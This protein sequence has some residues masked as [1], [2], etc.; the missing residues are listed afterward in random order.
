MIDG[1]RVSFSSIPL[2]VPGPAPWAWDILDFNDVTTNPAASVPAGHY[3][4]L[5][6]GN[7]FEVVKD[8]YSPGTGFEY[9]VVSPK[10][11]L[12]T[13]SYFSGVKVKYEIYFDKPFIMC[14]NP[15]E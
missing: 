15:V 8:D 2:P 7:G 11:G 3:P 14:S 13:K 12:S 5:S 9:G 6:W 4:G 1:I 10:Y